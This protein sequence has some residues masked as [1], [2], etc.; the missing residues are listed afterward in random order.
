MKVGTSTITVTSNDTTNGTITSNCT[1]TISENATGNYTLLCGNLDYT[2]NGNGPIM[3]TGEDIVPM[4]VTRDFDTSNYTSLCSNKT[5]K[6]I[7]LRISQAGKLTIGK[8]DLTKYGKGI[9]AT[10]IEPVEYDVT[11]GL[12]TLDVNIS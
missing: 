11:T 6:R 12:N 10:I 4:V 7:C 5:I 8:V 2:D 3:G 9:N 1:V